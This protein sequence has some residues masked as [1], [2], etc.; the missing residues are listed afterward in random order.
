MGMGGVIKKR[1][2]TIEVGKDV[3]NKRNQNST[4]YF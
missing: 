1:E 2:A 3:F 4:I